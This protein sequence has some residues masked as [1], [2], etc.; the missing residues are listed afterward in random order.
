M[1][2]LRFAC[3]QHVIGEVYDVDDHVLRAL[4]DLEG[5]PIFYQRELI[6]VQLSPD[7]ASDEIPAESDASKVQE[8]QIYFL[9]RFRPELLKLEFLE[10]Y[11]DSPSRPYTYQQ[12][13][14]PGANHPAKDVML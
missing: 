2:P 13:R 14:V 1:L 3:F 7:G 5:H 8:C 4:D 10:S 12:D 6:R 11:S 9:K